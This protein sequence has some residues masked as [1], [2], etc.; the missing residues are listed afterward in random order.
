LTIETTE[1][2]VANSYYQRK[3]LHVEMEQARMVL[4]TDLLKQL[5]TE[6]RPQKYCEALGEI[7]VHD[8]A[9]WQS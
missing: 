3:D 5:E 4:D 9:K 2:G 7:I 8:L 1:C 6:P